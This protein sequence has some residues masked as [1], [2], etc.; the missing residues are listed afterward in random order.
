MTEKNLETVEQPTD[1][2]EVWLAIRKEAGLNI[3]PE[4]AEVMWDYCYTIDPYNVYSDLHQEEKQIGRE[5]FAR[6]PGSNVWVNYG[7]LPDAT[8]GALRGSEQERR[9]LDDD[10]IPWLSEEF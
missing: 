6:A 8:L 5:Y 9:S 10:Q 3:D 7:D 4:T 2:L 1:T